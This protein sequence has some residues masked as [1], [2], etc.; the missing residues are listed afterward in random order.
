MQK[1]EQWQG[2]A[3]CNRNFA[4]NRRLKGLNEQMKE[5]NWKQVRRIKIRE[6]SIQWQDTGGDRTCTKTKQTHENKEVSTVV[7]WAPAHAVWLTANNF[8]N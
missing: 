3:A 4:V 2:L 7:P 1:N 5:A 6:G 8:T